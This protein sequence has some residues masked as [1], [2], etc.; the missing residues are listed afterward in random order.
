MTLLVKLWNWKRHEWNNNQHNAIR[1][2]SDSQHVNK[3]TIST[4]E[5]DLCFIET[6]L[7]FLWYKL[8]FILIRWQVWSWTHRLKS[9]ENI[10]YQFNSQSRIIIQHMFIWK[11]YSDHGNKCNHTIFIVIILIQLTSAQNLCKAPTQWAYSY[12][13]LKHSL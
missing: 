1:V 3:N 10:S 12:D 13:L 5:V 9:N 2:T 4:K 6:Y 7:Y 11:L 8:A